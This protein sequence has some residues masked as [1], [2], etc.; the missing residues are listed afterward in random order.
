MRK[1]A[2]S[3]VEDTYALKNLLGI[4]RVSA[5]LF[6]LKYNAQGNNA[7]P[8]FVFADIELS[9]EGDEVDTRVS[10]WALS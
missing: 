8:N 6:L 3:V 9:W 2:K 7:I 4:Q 10:K 5:A 1:E